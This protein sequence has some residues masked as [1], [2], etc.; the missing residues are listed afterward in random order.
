MTQ[1][2]HIENHI[3]DH[4]T[5]IYWMYQLQHHIN[6]NLQ[7]LYVIHLL[8][9]MGPVKVVAIPTN[10]E[11]CIFYVIGRESLCFFEKLIDKSLSE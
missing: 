5:D 11:W 1:I 9:Q 6:L 7:L 3:L 4:L 10:L 8:K 2:H